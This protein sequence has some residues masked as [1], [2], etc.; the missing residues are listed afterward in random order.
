MGGWTSCFETMP[1]SRSATKARINSRAVE[2][3][4]IPLRS[5]NKSDLVRKFVTSKKMRVDAISVQIHYPPFNS[6]ACKNGYDLLRNK[7]LGTR[8]ILTGGSYARSIGQY[9]SG[10]ETYQ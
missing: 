6:A 3:S 8:D 2:I 10:V 7:L 4:S 1:D 9:G 5:Q